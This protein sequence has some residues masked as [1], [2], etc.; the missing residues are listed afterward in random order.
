MGID[1]I[2]AIRGELPQRQQRL[3][4]AWA[5]LHQHELRENWQLLAKGAA[6]RK[7]QPL[8]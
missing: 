2:E 3:V 4:E 7:I 5:E 6:P 1:P 8:R